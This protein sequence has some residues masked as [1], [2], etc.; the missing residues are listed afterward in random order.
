MDY[1]KLTPV[2]KYDNV[3]V[4][5]DDLFKPFEDIPLNGGK[6]RQAFA[7]L[8]N[9]KQIIKEKYNNTVVTATSIHSP[10]G[11][12]IS[13]V[14]KYNNMN[15]YVFVGRTNEG[16]VNR[17]NLMH[18]VVKDSKLKIIGGAW[19]N[20][21][22]K[23]STDFCLENNY[24]LVNY[25]INLNDDKDAILNSII[26]QVKNLP[27]ELDYLVIP[28]GSGIT[29]SGILLGLQ[30]YNKK[31]K[32]VIG[33]QISGQ[34]LIN[35]IRYNL[36]FEQTCFEYYISNEY[37]YSKQVKSYIGDLLL[38]PIY[39]AKAWDYFI[40]NFDYRNKKVCFWVVGDTNTI[41]EIN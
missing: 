31:V 37:K 34:N 35:K 29:F 6:L 26:L 18:E 15:C 2:I 20:V 11:L 14:A 5:R 27:N 3:Y 24:F 7:L 39:E 16:V 21:L 9:N 13:K 41:R 17:N 4:K 38:D 33:V 8:E 22:K 36:G 12:I 23:Y 40:K 10:Q 25:G 19:N 28:I 30:K 32:H 1:L